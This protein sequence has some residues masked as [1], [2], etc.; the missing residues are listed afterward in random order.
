M[1]KWLP[2]LVLVL[3]VAACGPTAAQVRAARVA[4]YDASRH[5]IL[6]AVYGALED[7]R[8]RVRSAVDGV[9]WSTHRSFLLDGT[10]LASLR[11]RKRGGDLDVYTLAMMIEIRGPAGD[12]S[13]RVV[14]SITLSRPTLRPLALAPT[15]RSVPPWIHGQVDALYVR[16]HERLRAS[17]IAPAAP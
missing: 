12:R 2:S 13:I 4:H 11:F 10:A 14:P 3:A 7:S 8:Y 5:T 9:V 15:D 17:A 1:S 16:I 6:E